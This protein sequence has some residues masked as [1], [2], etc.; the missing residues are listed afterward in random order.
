[1][2]KIHKEESLFNLAIWNQNYIKKRGRYKQFFEGKILN[3]KLDENEQ[4]KNCLI[5]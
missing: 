3:V 1:M 2:Y 4:E 5:S